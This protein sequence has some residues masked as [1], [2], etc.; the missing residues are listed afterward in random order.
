MKIDIRL[1][2]SLFHSVQMFIKLSK[3]IAKLNI[4]SKS[5][6]INDLIPVLS[7]MDFIAWWKSIGS[8]T[9]FS[10]NFYY[11]QISIYVNPC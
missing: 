4:V 5:H 6:E 3:C 11:D 1:N 9:K 8:F 10:M 2:L 7:I